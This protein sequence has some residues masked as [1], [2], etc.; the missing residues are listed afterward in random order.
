MLI[1][2]KEKW[3]K[4]VKLVGKVVLITGASS[5]FGYL[6]ALEFAEK[7][8]KVIAA[9]RN[10]E[11]GARLI[12][13]ATKLKL[14]DKITLETLD[15][16]C[17]K[18]IAALAE[19]FEAKGRLDI[20]VNNAGYAGAGFAEEIPV[21]EYRE[22][23]E[24]NFFGAIAVTQAF[25]PLMRKRRS[26]R[27]IMMSSVSGQIGFPGLSPYVSSKFALEGFSESLR[28]ELLPFSIY[29]T[30]VEP[31]SYKTSIWTDGKRITEKSIQENSPYA[32]QMKSVEQYL[33]KSEQ[34]YGNPLEVAKKIV[35][36]AEA[37]KPKLRYKLGKGVGMTIF[38]K[39]CLPWKWWE[40]IVLYNLKK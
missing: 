33:Q 14:Q 23:L 20:L 25:L 1:I 16:T 13:E 30:L 8:Y 34:N 6:T 37:K 35:F 4:G 5:G 40:K 17:V 36:I 2:K 28:L 11:K 38:L 32:Q 3:I 18:S 10:M 7:G 31:G 24:T 15:V 21:D 12:K 9:V 26:G 22:Q 29:V 27:I 39:A 19:K